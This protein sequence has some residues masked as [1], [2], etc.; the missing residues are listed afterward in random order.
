MNW[1]FKAKAA[2]TERPTDKSSGHTFHDLPVASDEFRQDQALAGEFQQAFFSRTYPQVPAVHA[3][4]R[5]RLEFAHSYQPA[6]AVGGDFFNIEAVGPDTAGIF[7]ADVMGHGTRSA[8]I[9]AILRTLLNELQPQGRHAAHF[10]RQINQRFCS[11]L[12]GLPFTFFASATYFVADTTARIATF[13]SAGHPMPFFLHRIVG[14]I[15]R[16]EQPKP[17]GAALGIFPDDAY[18]GGTARLQDG[19]GLIFFTDG[20]YEAMNAAGEEFGLAR[21]E[22]VI[23]SNIYKSGAEIL[24]ALRASIAQFIGTAPLNDDI[25]L[26]SVDVTTKAAGEK[27]PPP[28]S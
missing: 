2:E 16:L 12:R 11:M 8:L 6:M 21:L 19:D 22:E 14:R 1:P 20:A 17:R 26:V 25:C 3:P 23:Q 4:G 15:S 24:A 27:P 7:I 9:T 13:S 18:G 10:M 5:L 28:S